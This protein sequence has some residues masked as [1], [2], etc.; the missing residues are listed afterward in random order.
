[1]S[2]V[3][4]RRCACSSVPCLLADVISTTFSCDGSI[5]HN[6]KHFGS[7]L[8]F[9]SRRIPSLTV[10]KIVDSSALWC[11][12]TPLIPQAAKSAYVISPCFPFGFL[13]LLD[14]LSNMCSPSMI[15][16]RKKDRHI[17]ANGC[18]DYPT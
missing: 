15:N 6:H 9:Y 14:T 11:C 16:V 8:Y 18:P 17:Q 12:L 3:K 2:P 7:E 13:L 4:L 1:M 10:G 5:Y